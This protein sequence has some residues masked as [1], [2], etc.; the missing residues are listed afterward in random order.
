V[1]A[2]AVAAGV[3][4]WSPCWYVEPG[5]SMG[6]ELGQRATVKTARGF[7]LPEPVADHRIGWIPGVSMMWAEGHPLAGGLAS[8][9]KL[10]QHLDDLVEAIHRADVPCPGG[11]SGL[12]RSGF[13]GLRRMDST[14]DVRFDSSAEGLAA[15][16]GIAGL[17]KGAPRAKLETIYSADGL[18]Y[19]TLYLI[20]NKGE[21]KGR[22]YDKG[23]ESGTAHRGLWIRP[24]DQRRFVK[25]TRRDV[26]DMGSPFVK[27]KFKQRFAPLW[28]MSKGV[29][30][31][32]PM[33]LASKINDLVDAGELTASQARRLAGHLV[34]QAAESVSAHSG[35]TTAW[36]LD[37][38]CREY[39]LV[40]ADG[41]MQE[42][43]VNLQDVMEEVMDTATWGQG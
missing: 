4:T 10:Q 16:A 23:V 12:N 37:R 15:M 20:G 25:E 34:L 5:G 33:V 30:V 8:P 9:D 38:E 29:T 13:A 42:V 43:E 1:G 28:Q 24:E 35:R 14:V 40:L 39:G 6:M 36:R 27:T 26:A 31:G 11:K 19:E 21:K 7:L 18:G 17:L 32:G 2:S 3:D 41:V 22:W